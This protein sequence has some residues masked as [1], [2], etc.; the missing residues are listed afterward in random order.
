MRPKTTIVAQAC[1]TMQYAVTPASSKNL[2]TGKGT[3]ENLNTWNGPRPARNPKP[4]LGLSSA[5]S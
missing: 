5:H 1:E 2:W 4:R 3:D